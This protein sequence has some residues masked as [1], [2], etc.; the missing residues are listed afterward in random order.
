MTAATHTLADTP[1]GPTV[2]VCAGR[3]LLLA[4]AVFGAANLVQ[5]GVLG[6]ALPWHEATL[7]LNW[8]VAAGVFIAALIRLR[9]IGGEAARRA[10]GWSRRA[11]LL[12]VGAALALAGASAVTGDWGL[13]PWLSVAT[14]I[15]YGLAWTIAFARTR[16]AGMALIAAVAAGGAAVV[17]ARL[18][19]ADQYLLQAATLALVALLPGLWLASGRRL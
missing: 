15:L 2:A 5:W 6:G 13:M 1:S 16:R 18:G 8:L 14:L 9:T 10:A 19:T 11:I 4:G 17:A 3:V 7:G 12:I